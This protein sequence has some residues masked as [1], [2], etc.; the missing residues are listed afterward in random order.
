ME[1]VQPYQTLANITQCI[2]YISTTKTINMTRGVPNSDRRRGT[3][4]G[5]GG[6]NL[7]VRHG[8]AR[9]GAWCGA[10]NRTEMSFSTSESSDARLA[11]LRS[12]SRRAALA[13]S[14]AEARVALR[15]RAN[16]I[17]IWLMRKLIIKVII[18]LLCCVDIPGKRNLNI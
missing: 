7:W 15:T 4:G 1:V 16:T 17:I 2:Y 13:S 14:T 12:L 5:E 3:G 9:C 6:L 10:G 8:E 18:I 11:R